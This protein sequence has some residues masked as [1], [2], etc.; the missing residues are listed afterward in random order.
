MS[1]TTRVL[2]ALVAGLGLGILAST[3]GNAALTAIAGWIEPVG[4]LFINGIRMTV[5]DEDLIVAPARRPE[6]DAAR[7]PEADAARRPEADAARRPEA[8]TAR[9]LAAPSPPNGRVGEAGL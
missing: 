2:A 7:R 5:I 8:D 4:T 9:P 1:L 3:T 6:A